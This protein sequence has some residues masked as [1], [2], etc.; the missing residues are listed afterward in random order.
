M[1]NYDDIAQQIADEERTRVRS[2]ALFASDANPD[3]AARAKTLGGQRGIPA[4]VALRNLPEVERRAYVDELDAMTKDRPAARAFYG[5]PYTAAVG[6]DD[7]KN[8]VDTEA[9]F[10]QKVISGQAVQGKIGERYQRPTTIGNMRGEERSALGTVI[11]PLQRGYSRG[12]QGIS[13]LLNELG[14]MRGLE[15]QQ[16]DAAQA[17]GVVV[18]PLNERAVRMA[19]QQRQIER[20]PVPEEVAAGLREIGSATSMSEALNAVTSNPRAVLEVVLESMGTSAPSLAAAVGGGAVGG[21][22]GTAIGAGAGSFATEFGATM[23]DVMSEKGMDPRDPMSIRRALGDPEIMAAAREKA[24]KRAVPIAIFD[25]LTAGLAGRLLSGATSSAA[26]VAARSAGEV[27]VQAGG[28]A[29]GEAVAQAAT[30][31]YKPG[32]IVLEALAE[33]P[34][35]FVEGASNFRD[36]MTKARAA[37]ERTQF[38]D[39]LHK[40]AKASKVAQR[41]PGSFEAFIAQAAEGAE[42]QEVYVDAQ[43]LNQLGLAEKLAEISPSV[44]QQ[45]ATALASGGDVAIPVAEYTAR[46]ATT[47]MAPALLDHLRVAPDDLSR[48]EATEFLQSAPEKFQTELERITSQAADTMATQLSADAVRQGVLDQLNTANRFTP[49]VN[50]AYASLT[51]AFYASTAAR[52][53]ITPEEMYKRYPLRVQGANP[54]G[55]LVEQ[56]GVDLTPGGGFKTLK[57]DHTTVDYGVSG[58][59]RRM[60]INMVKTPPAARGQGSAR[61]ALTQLLA[62]ADKRGM[63]VVLTAEPM[64][65]KTSKAKLEAFYKSLGFV[66]NKGRSKDFTTM[67]GMV[68]EPVAP[69]NQAP[70]GAQQFATTFT[71]ASGQTYDVKLDQQTLGMGADRQLAVRVT[72]TDPDTGAARGYVDFAVDGNTLRGENLVVAPGSRG[73][74]LAEA[75]YKAAREAGYDIA[76]GRSQTPDGDAFVRALQERGVINAQAPDTLN[77]GAPEYGMTHRPPGPEDGA[78]LHDLTGGGQIYPDDVYGARGAQFYGTGDTKN[79]KAVFALANKVRG[80]PDAQVTI[81]RAVP[82]EVTDAKINPGDW[83]TINKAYAEMHGEGFENGYRVLEIKAKASEIYTNGDSI[84]EWG[85]WPDTLNQTDDRTAR[86]RDALLAGRTPEQLSPE[87]RAQLDALGPVD[88]TETPEFKAWFGDSK[89][90][91][92]N[93]KPLVVYHGTYGDF[94]E[95]KAKKGA[96]LGFHFGDREAANTR[97]EDTADGRLDAAGIEQA[98]RRSD[99]FFADLKAFEEQLRRRDSQIPDDEFL[100]ALESGDDMGPLS[101]KYKYKPTD[102]EQAELARLQEQY[103]ASRLPIMKTGVG[104]NIGQF[105]LSASKLL[106]LPDVGNWGGVAEVRKALPWDSDARTLKVLAEEIKSRGYDGIVY[107]NTVENPVMKTDSYIVF[108]PEQIKSAIGNRGT[109]DP[110]DPS[111]LNQNAGA[112]GTFSPSTLTISLLEKADLSTFLHETGHFF[113]EALADMAAQPGAPADVVADMNKVLEWFG[114]S[115][116]ATWRAMSLEQQRQYHEKFAESF[117]QYLFEGK[118]PS[119]DLQPLFSRFRAWLVN[120]YRSLRQF[121]ATYNTQLSDEVRGVFDRMIATQEQIEE[122]QSARG[123]TPVYASAAEAGMTPE[124]WAKYQ[125]TNTEATE[126]AIAQLQAR[127]LRDLKWTMNARGREL[128]KISKDVAEKRKAVE[129]EVKEQVRSEPVFAVQRWLKT[130]VLADGTKTVGAKLST[131]AL[132]EMYGD[133]PAAPWRYLATNMIAAEDGMHPDV[134]AEMFGYSSGDEMVR[135]IVAAFPEDSEIQGRTDQRMLERYGDLSTEAGIARAADQAVHNEA[136]ARFVATELAALSKAT[137]PVRAMTQAAKQFAAQLVARRKVKDVKPAQ[138]AAAETRA[139]K[140]AATASAAGKTQEAITAKRDQLLNFYATKESTA[141]LEEVDKGLKYL[142]KVEGST[143]LSPDYKEQIDALLERFDLRRSVTNR[144]LERRASLVEWVEAQ[145]EMGVEPAIPDGLLNEALRKSYKDMTVEEF[146][147]LLDSVKQ[148]EHL[149]RL[150]QKLLTAK[151]D[152]AFDAARQEIVDSILANAGDREADTRTPNTVLGS[153]LLGLKKF[154]AAHIKAATLARVMDGG[155]DGGPMWE[156]IIRAANTAGDKEITMRETATRELSAMIG[157]LL[158]TGA[159]GGKGLY[160]PAIG[161]SMNREARLAVALNTGNASNLQRLMGGEGWNMQQVNEITSTLTEQEWRFVQRVWD[162]F[163]GYRAEIGA[164]EKRVNGVEPNWVEAAPREV[165]TADGK[166]VKL[167]GGYYPVKYDP[168]ASERAEAHN[169]AEAARQQMRGAYTSATTRRSFTKER[170]D[171][172]NGRPL[173]YSLDGIYNGVNEVIHDLSWHEFLIDANRLMRDKTIS[174]AMRQKYGPEAHQ[175]F[176]TWLQDVATGERAAAN[177]GE[178]ALGWVRQGVS[179]SGLGLNVM[180]ALIQPLGITQS[181][182]RVGP[183]FIGRGVAQFI[184]SPLASVDTVHAKSDFMRTRTMTRFREL[185]EVR[186]QVKGQ[187]KARRAV[188]GAAYYLMLRAQQL[189][190]VPTWLGAYEKAITEGNGEER[191]VALADQAVIDA[192]GSGTTKD[193]SAI[194]RGGQ[195]QR[196]FTVFYSFF[197]TAL[198]LGVMQTMTA[199]SKAQ[200]AAD[201]LLLYVAP[202]LLGAFLKDAFTPGDSGDDDPEKIAKK[203]AGE[204]ISYLMGLMF[205]VRELGGAVQVLTGTNQYG[206]DYSGPAGLRPIT[207]MYKLAKQANQ[208]EADD[209][210]RKAIIN[211]AGE[212]LRLPA[213]QI[214]RSITGAQALANGDTENPLAVIFGYQEPK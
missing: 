175:Q 40:L 180:S 162:Y 101:D 118:A 97:L 210:L 117:E 169:D 22:A 18:D 158:K 76:P 208:G 213:A 183:K 41:D 14:V 96:H 110:N 157:P 167:R 38:L 7:A 114:V 84:Q 36:T 88:Q 17:G 80:N 54:E 191:A 34:T 73:R 26:S 100:A 81:Y 176:K 150:K 55:A 69:L 46:I 52:Y 132:R 25:A 185:A 9:L 124:E 82:I 1:S 186:A 2:S 68:R 72:V 53:G 159:M 62:E 51:S 78:P 24:V 87:E 128:R 148:I 193:Q 156:Y 141:V 12:L 140:R 207:D 64:D 90:V 30:G 144:E 4:D 199:K 67:A 151:N 59:G 203:L 204:Q 57:V 135:A 153:A 98:N 28:G 177:A 8:L 121:M 127:S 105:Y 19:E 70:T 113:L 145:R 60:E 209:A 99:L 131:S 42:V 165:Q 56:G 189:V 94:T 147:G 137:T 212:L 163:E 190:D 187:T 6:K 15:R 11:E 31:E 107:A 188:D 161:R 179:V 35:G 136:R 160:I 61:A 29:A 95:F 106:R 71:D 202:V 103:A 20:F 44:G 102:E 115:D 91:D 16:A 63:Q 146:R 104:A 195:A 45:F 47:D 200:L 139:A 21:P 196:L 93:G 173:L 39:N 86:Y 149:G 89:V 92:A 58:D 192:Q 201:Y 178:T 111:I 182:V 5:T 123:F 130:G 75:M 116:L 168:R 112:R 142:A 120:V 79:D 3:Q 172:V 13:T 143:T 174:A 48:A 119:K 66:P 194:E 49:D 171:E 170:V 27:G 164:K 33:I 23:G 155:K 85:Y 125:A 154:Y 37:D 138:H 197:N 65:K 126:E 214:N 77:Q 129:A 10:Q 74:G 83:V 108:N 50:E 184:G 166:T 134:V 109:F 205:G 32:D 206:S 211:T 198:N 181:I 152:R 122:L 133:S 43:V